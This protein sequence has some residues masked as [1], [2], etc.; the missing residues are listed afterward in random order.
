MTPDAKLNAAAELADH[1]IGI[2]LSTKP[3]LLICSV[4]SA[5]LEKIPRYAKKLT[6]FRQQL[7]NNLS[8][9]AIPEAPQD[10]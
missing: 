2:I 5:E 9:Q 6:D 3:D 7:I 8:Q 10:D 1:Y 4:S